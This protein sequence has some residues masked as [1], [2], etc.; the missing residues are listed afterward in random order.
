MP[1]SSEQAWLLPPEGTEVSGPFSPAAF[2][3][4]VGYGQKPDRPFWFLLQTLVALAIV[5]TTL[6]LALWFPCGLCACVTLS[7]PFHFC[8]L[9]SASNHHWEIPS[10]T[11]YAG[12]LNTMGLGRH[13]TYVPLF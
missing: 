11:A 3:S 13:R 9:L 12:C 1:N 2:L 10:V 6:S 7:L 5:S 4:R 8:L